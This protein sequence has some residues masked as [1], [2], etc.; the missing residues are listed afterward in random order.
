MVAGDVGLSHAAID[1]AVS[2]AGF[3]VEACPVDWRVGGR[4]DL[5]GFSNIILDG[6]G[7][8]EIAV[9]EWIGLIAYRATGK[10]DDLLPGPAPK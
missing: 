4:D 6:L 8:T 3:A 1:R 7:R 9:R 2:K 10:I 5:L